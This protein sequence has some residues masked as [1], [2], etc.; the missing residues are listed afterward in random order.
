MYEP[1]FRAKE[2][3]HGPDHPET[4]KARNAFAQCLGR[5]IG[6]YDQAAVHWDA[7]ISARR[8]ALGADHADTLAIRLD[9]AEFNIVRKAYDIAEPPLRE[10]LGTCLTKL[11]PNHAY[12]LRAESDLVGLY[13]E[14]GELETA[15]IL[16]HRA[17]RSKEEDRP[18]R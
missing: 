16:L 5:F 13:L 9:R 6:L 14:R 11:G 18:D 3:K 15:E 7:V 1:A 4:L 8:K 2:A 17:L 10:I 12:V